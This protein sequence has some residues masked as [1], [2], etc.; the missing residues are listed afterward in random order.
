MDFRPLLCLSAMPLELQPLH[1]ALS[2]APVGD[3]AFPLY[4]AAAQDIFLLHT[5]I[6][7]VNTAYSVARA[8]TQLKLKEKIEIKTVLQCGIGGSFTPE[9]AIGEV[10]LASSEIDMDAGIRYENSWQGIETL[11]FSLVNSYANQLPTDN[12]WTDYLAKKLQLQCVPFA[13]SDAITGDK[14]QTRR[15]Q[16]YSKAIIESMEG[17]AAAQACQHF[18]LPFAEMRSISNYV[19]VRDKSLW[20]IPLA[21]KNLNHYTL[22]IISMLE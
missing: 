1:D 4:Y 19:G 13:T 15:Q 12:H 9:H 7:K 20:N 14:E 10:L 11:G 8:I 3:G 17:S 5:G 16:Q 21:I 18:Q 22:K 2:F 6:A